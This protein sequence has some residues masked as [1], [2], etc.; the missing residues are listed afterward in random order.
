MSRAFV[1][2]QDGTDAFEEL[3]EK[4][5]SEHPNLVT[6]RGLAL[7]EGEVA[8]LNRAYAQAQAAG[9]RAALNLAA[10]DLRYW[11]A[12]LASAQ[13]M[14]EPGP[15]GE[16]RFGSHVTIVRA[17]GRR[18][19]FRIVGEDEADPNNGTLSFVSPL[20]LALMGKV[21]EDEVSVGGGAARI[22]SVE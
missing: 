9:E 18:Q 17:D 21:V 19:T 15:G 3:P 14:P 11:T 12:R 4:R 1:K 22:V 5:V 8:R 16:V 7:I 2:E 10:R 13:P 20:A 6:G